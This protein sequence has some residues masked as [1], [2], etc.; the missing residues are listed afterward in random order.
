MDRLRTAGDGGERPHRDAHDVVLRLLGRE[1]DPPV[2]AW[3][4]RARAFGFVEPKRSAMIDAQ[5]R[6]AA[7][8][9]DLL[10]EVVVRVEEERE[11]RAE[12]VRR[13]PGRNRRLAVRDPVRERER[14]LLHRRR[15]RLADVVAGDQIVFHFGSR[16]CAYAKRFAVICIDGPGG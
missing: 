5:R 2:C 12:L 8:L 9:R 1:V 16:S 3:N 10:E 13:E 14:E 11:A 15:A 7:E 4:R 6:R